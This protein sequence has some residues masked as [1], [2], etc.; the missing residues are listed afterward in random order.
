MNRFIGKRTILY[1]VFFISAYISVA[2]LPSNVLVGYHENWGTLKLSQ[3]QSNY[4]VICLSFG[5]PV[6]YPAVGYDI[7]Y[8]IPTAYT[9]TS[10]QIKA[11][12]MSDIDALH[13]AGKKVLL[14]IG[15]ATG[16]VMLSTTAQRDVFISSVNLIFSDYNYK[17]DGIDLDLESSSMAFGS[18][19]TITSPAA[20][21]T[22]MV[23][24]V[25]SIMSNYQTQTGKKMLL[26]ATPEV[27]YLMGGLSSYQVTNLNGGAFLP[28]LDG[29]RNDIDLLQMQLY[30]AGGSNG[31]VYA[32]NGTIYFD[33][34]TADFALAMNESII[35]GFT[36]VGGK[37]TITGITENK[38]AFGLPATSAAS[39]ASTGYVTAAN[40]C[41]AVK[42]FRGAI[43][44]PAGVTYTMSAS[45]PAFKGLMT[46]S[47]NEDY[48]SVNGSWN[49]ALNF[50][51]AFP[52][53]AK[54]ASTTT[55]ACFN[56]A[57]TFTD[58]STN[59]PTS[60]SWNFGSGASTLTSN[61]QNPGP[62][63][64]STGGT[65]IITLTATN[66]GGSNTSSYTLT[67]SGIISSSGSIS[68]TQSV[69]QASSQTYSIPPVSNA[70]NY[71]W[72]VPSGSTI[73][74]GNGTTSIVVTIGSTSGPIS[75]LP[76]NTC[77]QGSAIS[78][79]IS[80]TN[81]TTPAITASASATTICAGTSI[82]LTASPTN[83]GTAPTYQWKKG[84][85]IIS[86][87]TNATYTTTTATN[88]DSYTVTMTSNAT[89]TSAASVT[90]SAVVITVSTFLTAAISITVTP[91]NS[92]YSGQSVTFSASY[93]NGGSSPTFQWKKGGTPISGETNSS[94]TTTSLSN[95][96]V[97][98]ATMMSNASCVTTSQ[99]SSNSITMTVNANPIFD[100]NLTGPTSVNTNQTGVGYSVTNQ[101]GM[102]YNWSIPSGASI[103]SGQGTNS[104]VVSFGNTS[105]DISLL[106]TNPIN[107]STTITSIITVGTTTDVN[108]QINTITPR[109]YP[110]P[111]SG[112]VTIELSG[113][114]NGILTYIITDLSGIII[115]SE[116]IN[117]SGVSIEIPT[118]FSPGMYQLQLHW[119]N[120]SFTQKICKY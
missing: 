2:Q 57:V 102:T 10:A 28:I 61:V 68:G 99:V 108:V 45:Y 92:I 26:T 74:S 30:N 38:I 21:Q 96:S 41:N 3:I 91:S 86:S 112:S 81:I 7:R 106:E 72:T 60:W 82:T 37:G 40:V 89:C 13:A 109:I 113:N 116:T 11:A 115:C 83:G 75:V 119:N 56:Q 98:S 97:I 22:N 84:G 63:S 46:W 6:N 16:P 1:F 34:G 76:S 5:L 93:S 73:T 18:S 43:S 71:S 8:S 78:S 14:S 35:K 20:G 12:F 53:V 114:T 54:I 19:W 94:Y 66:A 47:I 17:I 31:G 103:L 29:L 87:A 23:N 49:F 111:C 44:K 77:N 100:T 105:G 79:T 64:Y 69:C 25:K 120:Q 58:I 95:N 110:V 24:A 88:N 27:V 117:Y 32:W 80:I 9:G 55:T 67:I 85:S 4:N 70:T 107:Q 15:G 50:P 33:N 62:V 90:S 51:C 48:A 118:V 36:C 65:K 52:P 101:P 39:T 59:T 42:Y 104:I